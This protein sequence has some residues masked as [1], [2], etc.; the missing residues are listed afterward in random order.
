MRF[1]FF[2]LLADQNGQKIKTTHLKMKRAR[3][4]QQ[5]ST[6]RNRSFEALQFETV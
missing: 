6:M 5:I 3:Q 2:L 1:Y 4:T